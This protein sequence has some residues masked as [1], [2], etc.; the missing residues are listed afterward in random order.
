MRRCAASLRAVAG[1][2][3]ALAVAGA[4]TTLAG[5]AP[6]TSDR[7]QPLA[8]GA[9]V[10]TG[11]AAVSGAGRATLN[12]A[13]T[14]QG[15]ELTYAFEYGPTV[16]YGSTT[17]PRTLP[18]AATKVA[19][20]AAVTGLSAGTTYHYRLVARTSDGT[21]I[22]GRDRTF[23]TSSSTQAPSA[24]TSAAT[25]IGADRATLHGRVNPGGR[26]TTYQFEWG[27]TTAYGSVTASTSAG[28]GA[29]G[30]PVSVVLTGL[31]PGATYHYRVVATNAA[32]TDRGGDRILRT[33]RGLTGISI[34]PSATT[35]AWNGTVVL[36]GALTGAAVER[37]PVVLLRQDHP[38]SAGFR[39]AGIATTDAAGR[40][41]FRLGRVYASTRVKVQAGRG[42]AIVSPVVS[43]GS[44]L[45]VRLRAERRRATTVRLVGRV[46]PAR[47]D[48]RARIE[49]QR[50]D[51]SWKLVRTVRLRRLPSGRSTFRLT[52][53]RLRD[54]AL[55]RAVVDPRDGG[56][57]VATTTPPVQ[58]GARR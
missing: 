30:M 13:I 12:G 39:Q 38:Y 6:G 4:P 23:S 10:E 53:G 44:Q 48:G 52:V 29:S 21:T 55:Y 31:R 17:P 37:A 32:G 16:A 28:S 36:S 15:A 34:V 57:H 43:I 7:G 18:A 19:V 27:H 58:V 1:L 40:Y 47:P 20:R 8:A 35:V 24:S 41:S 9:S 56:A 3:A 2:A 14:P 51:G 49:R 26:P 33:S 25:E 50:A 46:Y 22:A 11:A 42:S 5:P 45:F 54:A